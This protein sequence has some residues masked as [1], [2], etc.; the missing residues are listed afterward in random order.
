M[1]CL[2]IPTVCET[3]TTNHIDI[4]DLGELFPDGYNRGSLNIA[5]LCAQ[6]AP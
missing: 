3:C 5:G 2:L 6:F 1:S 4:T